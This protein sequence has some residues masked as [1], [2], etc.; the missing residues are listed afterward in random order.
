MAVAAIT[1]SFAPLT[2]ILSSEANTNFQDL[3]SFLNGE[4]IHKDASVAFTAIPSG[5]ALDPISDNQLPRKAYVDR[6]G[7]I[8]QQKLTTNAA[9]LVNTN[10]TDMVLNNVPVVAGCTYAIHLHTGVQPLAV[11]A[12]WD[13]H[14]QVNAVDVGRVGIVNEDDVTDIDGTVYWVAPTTQAT[15]DIRIAGLEQSGSSSL[16]LTASA[17][18]PRYL[19]IIGLGVI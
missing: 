1:Y 7:G 8:V 14:V 18:L 15:D 12:R 10:P 17:T 3:V 6:L 11:G 2:D 4:V 19:T 16:V 5:P 9:P 13:L